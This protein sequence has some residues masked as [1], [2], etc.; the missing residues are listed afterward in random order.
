MRAQIRH[1][2][3]KGRAV[4]RNLEKIKMAELEIAMESAQEYQQQLQQEAA[5]KSIAE[6]ERDAAKTRLKEA[7]V[8]FDT[9]LALFF[10]FVFFF[11]FFSSH[12]PFSLPL[13]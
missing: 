10:F 5:D 6:R 13:S 9:S 7:M 8:R 2:H 4:A 1:M 3:R 12:P 11:W